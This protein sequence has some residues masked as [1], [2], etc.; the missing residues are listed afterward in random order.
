[1]T[2]NVVDNIS[3][4][5]K[6]ISVQQFITAGT[7]TYTP[8]TNMLYCF[9]QICGGGGAGGSALGGS[10]TIAAAGGGSPG[11][12]AQGWLSA[13]SIGASQSLTI[14]AAGTPG[15]AGNIP[16]NAG[17]TTTFGTSPVFFTCPGG[18]G[19]NGSAANPGTVYAYNRG[20]LSANAPSADASV[21]GFVGS[22]GRTP[23]FALTVP[24][25]TAYLSG[26]GASGN[27]GTGGEGLTT[28]GAGNA[29]SGN[30]SGGG[31]AT[32]STTS[33][34]GGPGTA[35]IIIITEYCK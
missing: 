22:G 3:N 29:G 23:L 8:T 6:T 25:L 17:G 15:T 30:G 18:I 7:F 21:I 1:M 12:Y 33:T 5:F 20:G 35:G 31:G 24:S 16:G 28:I 2:Q 32:A 34:Q 13:A 10:S 4:G 26:K 11:A 9:I 27:F 14:G 19:G